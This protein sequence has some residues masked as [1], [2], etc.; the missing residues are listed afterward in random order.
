NPRPCGS[1]WLSNRCHVDRRKKSGIKRY[2]KK[3]RIHTARNP[4]CGDAE[5]LQLWM[6]RLALR[7]IRRPIITE[8]RLATH[9][10]ITIQAHRE[11]E[12]RSVKTAINKLACHGIG[13]CVL[14]SA[15][16]GVLFALDVGQDERHAARVDAN[17]GLRLLK[18]NFLWLVVRCLAF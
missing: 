12:K 16:I 4:L 11:R 1:L 15:S 14:A 9:H 7:D 10:G 17:L 5:L 13:W 18:E 8:H 2:Q 6:S 3:K